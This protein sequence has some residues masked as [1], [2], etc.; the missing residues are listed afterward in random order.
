MSQILQEKHLCQSR[1]LAPA[2]ECGRASYRRGIDKEGGSFAAAL[3]SLP[4]KQDALNWLDV[5][6]ASCP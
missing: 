5:A 6:W 1:E 2:L 4:H 3:Q